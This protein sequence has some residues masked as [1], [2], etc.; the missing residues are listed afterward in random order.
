MGRKKSPAQLLLLFLPL[1]FLL[2]E[3]Q[4][5]DAPKPSRTVDLKAEFCPEASQ[6]YNIPLAGVDFV[7]ENEVLVYTVCRLDTIALSRRDRFLDTDPYHLKAVI[8]NISTG[9]IE[10]RFNWPTRGKGSG[11]YVT[12]SG[13]LLLH[14]DNMLELLSMDGRF[15]QHSQVTGT[16]PDDNIFVW[17]S[18]FS[19][20]IAVSEGSVASDSPETNTA[21]LNSRN[22]HLL[23]RWRDNA[24]VWSLA[25][26]PREV[27]RTAIDGTLLVKRSLPSGR[28]SILSKG[29]FRSFGV[30]IFVNDRTFAVP[31]RDN[32]L[33]YDTANGEQTTFPCT[34]AIRVEASRNASTLGVL[35]A[36]FTNY[37]MEIGRPK[38]SDASVDI[39]E[40]PGT[41]RLAS[42][43]L[44][45]GPSFGF[46]FAISPEGS[47]LAV[48]DHMS[49]S[50]FDIP[51]K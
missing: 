47:K 21:I 19:D 7:S 41:Q 22:L 32:L 1:V 35:C 30:P 5:A 4:A 8:V 13:D 3:M 17:A 27:V 51:P 29:P 14:R 39:Y 34:S 9:V 48:V 31:V 42:I 37:L 46:D 36:K 2:G 24:D 6:Q 26:S 50:L 15:F 38:L 12:H 49:V 25:V 18:H 10:R 16:T 45:P 23:Q 11:L 43:P 28:W 20:L 44:K 40:L 33:L